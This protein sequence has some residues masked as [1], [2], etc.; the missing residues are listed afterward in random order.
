MRSNQSKISQTLSDELVTAEEG[1]SRV[2]SR[3]NTSCQVG[4]TEKVLHET[5]L[6]LSHKL[7]ELAKVSDKVF[8]MI[9]GGE[10]DSYPKIFR[11][12]D[13]LSHISALEISRFIKFL[14]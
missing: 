13:S 6:S 2:D 1:G 3:A 4:S 11:K 12:D 10:V 7:D 9:D 8:Q 5:L 14:L